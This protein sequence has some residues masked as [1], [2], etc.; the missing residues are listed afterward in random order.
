MQTPIRRSMLFMPATNARALAKA[1]TL[2][3]DSVIVDLEDAVHPDRRDEA[4]ACV[5]SLRDTYHFGRRE[6]LLRINSLQSEHWEQDLQA[7]GS[8]GLDGIVVPKVNSRDDLERLS[9]QLA[10]LPTLSSQ[11]QS[12]RLVIMIETPV[13]VVNAVE[14]CAYPGVDAVLVGT[15]DLGAAMRLSDTPA[16]TGL[17]FALQQVVMAAKAANIAV[18]DGVYMDVQDN[19]GLEQECLQGKV[20][21]FD[22]KTLIHPNQLAITNRIYSPSERALADARGLV[23]AWESAERSGEAV[24]LYQQRLV[25]HLHVTQARH[26]LALAEQMT[27]IDQGD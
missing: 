27:L 19:H 4:R 5:R 18:I 8:S 11:Q 14:V 7:F 23:A 20:L 13:G 12:P 10:R 21:G 22:G 24:C 16:R 15:A 6:V 2:P 3:A 17:Q 1:Q 26:L 25:E 9:A